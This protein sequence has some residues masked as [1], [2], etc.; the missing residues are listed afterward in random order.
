MSDRNNTEERIR[1]FGKNS[2]IP[3]QLSLLL[4]CG[5]GIWVVANFIHDIRD[6]NKHTKED[7]E[8][9]REDTMDGIDKIQR[10]LDKSVK[11]NWSVDMEEYSWEEFK[12]YNDTNTIPDVR[13]IKQRLSN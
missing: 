8:E 3:I 9:L 1:A 7:V 11:Q 5:V 4:A 12:L 13:K 10:T 2:V 6:T